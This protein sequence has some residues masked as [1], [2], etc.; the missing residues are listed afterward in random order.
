MSQAPK[1]P[2]KANLVK[3]IEMVYGFPGK[4]Q[5]GWEAERLDAGHFRVTRANGSTRDIYLDKHM[6]LKDRSV[7]LPKVDDSGVL[8][9]GEWS[10]V[11]GKGIKHDQHARRRGKT[12]IYLLMGP[13][14]RQTAEVTLG[15]P[16]NGQAVKLLD[17]HLLQVGEDIIPVLPKQRDVTL[18]VFASEYSGGNLSYIN[19]HIPGVSDSRK[20]APAGA[21]F[22]PKRA[23]EPA[24]YKEIVGGQLVTTA[25]FQL[26]ASGESVKYKFR[27]G[28]TALL[29]MALAKKLQEARNTALEAGIEPD[30]YHTFVEINDQLLE[31]HKKWITGNMK[32]D[33]GRDWFRPAAPEKNHDSGLEP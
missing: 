25:L 1:D 6:S 33:K 19:L 27:T 23:G 21:F 3:T 18:K 4:L 9:L 30:Q 26:N 22:R 32:I 15:I 28:E 17:S 5:K 20:N 13:T 2:K 29:D 10:V 8:M 24:Q 12:K 31:N 14:G 7:V 16:H 11:I